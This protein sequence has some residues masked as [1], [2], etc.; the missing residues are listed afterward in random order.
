MRNAE[1]LG[2]DVLHVPVEL[3]CLRNHGKEDILNPYVNSER[4]RLLTPAPTGF[5]MTFL[6]GPAL[7]MEG[8]PAAFAIDQAFHSSAILTAIT[9]TRNV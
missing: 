2:V 3:L 5:L 6:P 1:P 7:G 8:H 4:S 9:M